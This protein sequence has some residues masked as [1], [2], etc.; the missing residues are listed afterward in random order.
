MSDKSNLSQEMK[1]EIQKACE[2]KE[3]MD[4]RRKEFDAKKS[5]MFKE[6]QK[7]PKRGNS[8]RKRSL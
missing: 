1:S 5:E 8:Q 7:K 4:E 6:I 3:K 2:E